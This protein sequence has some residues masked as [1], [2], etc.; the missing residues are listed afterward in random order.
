MGGL[1]EI[2]L[3]DDDNGVAQ[4]PQHPPTTDQPRFLKL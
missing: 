4:P 1:G 3:F 2:A